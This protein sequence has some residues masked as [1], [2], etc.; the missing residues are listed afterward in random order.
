[1]AMLR[2]LRNLLRVGISARHHELV[3]RRL[4]DPVRARG[5]EPGSSEWLG[6]VIATLLFENF[7]FYF[8]RSFLWFNS[9]WRESDIRET[10]NLLLLPLFSFLTVSQDIY[11]FLPLS[12]ICFVFSHP[13]TDLIEGLSHLPGP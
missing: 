10:G 5:G 6:K 4:Q 9:L 7:P 11:S 1:M 2:N 3:L 12:N 13:P 8:L